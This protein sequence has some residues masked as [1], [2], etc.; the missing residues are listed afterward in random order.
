MR[1]NL[2]KKSERKYVS[3]LWKKML[4]N[5]VKLKKMWQ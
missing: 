3:K 1:K 2:S 4:V 5:N